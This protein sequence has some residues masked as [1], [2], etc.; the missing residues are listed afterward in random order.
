VFALFTVK[1]RTWLKG[2]IVFLVVCSFVPIL[3]S[4]FFLFNSSYY[5]RWLYMM[6]LMTSLATIVAL[7]DIKT[8]WQM[9]SF[10]NTAICA[11]VAI[12]LGLIWNEN[13]S[14]NKTTLGYPP[15]INRFWIYVGLAFLGII[16]TGFI[17]KKY[18]GTKQFD[19]AILIGVSVMTV[20]YG[21]I[22]I[23]DGK[24]YSENSNFMVGKMG[25]EILSNRKS[26][27]R[28]PHASVFTYHCPNCFFHQNSFQKSLAA[29]RQGFIN[30]AK[31]KRFCTF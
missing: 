2:L 11:I 4:M 20:L 29:A 7:E 24:K 10:I 28:F 13:A 18:R 22:H 3:N 21:C 1:K 19:S 6:M 25:I 27:F 26:D 5:A 15:Y 31:R 14:N 16:A 23:S 8:N 12:A 9:P 17:I 30:I